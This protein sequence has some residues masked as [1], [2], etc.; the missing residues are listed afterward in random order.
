MITNCITGPYC[1]MSYKQ[2]THAVVKRLIQVPIYFAEIKKK[3]KRKSKF[4]TNVHNEIDEKFYHSDQ[5]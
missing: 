1:S 2:Y 5:N 3:R 4:E